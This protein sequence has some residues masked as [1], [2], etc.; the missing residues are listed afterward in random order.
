MAD[1]SCGAF[2]AEGLAFVGRGAFR[3]N[4]FEQFG[5]NPAAGGLAFVHFFGG[6][7]AEDVDVAEKR[8]AQVCDRR[9]NA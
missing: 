9:G 3:L 1:H 2:E 6:F 7:G 5:S 8:S 4:F